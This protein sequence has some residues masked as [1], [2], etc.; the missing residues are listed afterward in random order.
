MLP[1]QSY[2]LSQAGRPKSA[3][4]QRAADA[5]SGELAAAISRPIMAASARIRAGLRVSTGIKPGH[6]APP[7]ARDTA[8][9]AGPVARDA[10]RPKA[11][12]GG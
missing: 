7:R 3:A 1:Y 12:V 5:R 6:H 9:H 11:S 10:A 4:E 2:Q 8:A